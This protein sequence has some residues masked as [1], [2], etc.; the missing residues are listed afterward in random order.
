M[1]STEPAGVNIKI[2]SNAMH[3]ARALHRKIPAP[4]PSLAAK[5][6]VLR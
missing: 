1:V 3:R 4:P 5:L 2:Q 6:L